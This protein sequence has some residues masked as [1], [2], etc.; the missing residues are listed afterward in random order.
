MSAFLGT[1]VRVEGLVGV[2]QILV[3]R[4]AEEYPGTTHIIPG[5]KHWVRVASNLTLRELLIYISRS[6]QLCGLCEL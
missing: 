2:L 4:S 1:N 6:C 3:V 5:I